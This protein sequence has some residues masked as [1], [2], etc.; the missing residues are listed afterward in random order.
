MRSLRRLFFILALGAPPLSQGIAQDNG[1][2][3]AIGTMPAR[4]M[5]AEQVIKY[6]GP[7]EQKIPAV[8]KPPIIRWI[9]EGFVVYFENTYVI[10]AIATNGDKK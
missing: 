7:P 5:L 2:D 9:Y 1:K 4:G 6:F 8:G 10:H 3:E